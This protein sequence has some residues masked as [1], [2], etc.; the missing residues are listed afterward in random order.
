MRCGFLSLHHASLRSKIIS[1]FPLNSKIS[2]ASVIFMKIDVD[3]WCKDSVLGWHGWMVM[4]RCRGWGQRVMRRQPLGI[5]RY[6]R[7]VWGHY[8]PRTRW[9]HFLWSQDFLF[10]MD[11]FIFDCSL[12]YSSVFSGDGGVS[13]SVSYPPYFPAFL[14]LGIVFLCTLPVHTGLTKGFWLL[15]FWL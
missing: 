2:R 5:Q 15:W 13:Q 1:Q 8:W 12:F 7:R 3:A 9:D 11:I 10:G 6:I 4:S 14:K